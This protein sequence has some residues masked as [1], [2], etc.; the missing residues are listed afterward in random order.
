M[1]SG[2]CRGLRGH[3]RYPAVLSWP[4]AFAR[5][6][7]LWPGLVSVWS[8]DAMALTLQS[9]VCLQSLCCWNGHSAGRIKLVDRLLRALTQQWLF[10][11]HWRASHTRHQG[12]AGMRCALA[13]RAAS[14][15]ARARGRR[16]AAGPSSS[17]AACA[18]TAHCCAAAQRRVHE[19]PWRAQC[20]MRAARR[21]AQDCM[22]TALRGAQDC[23]H[24]AQAGRAQCCTTDSNTFQ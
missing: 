10:P 9:H 19:A 22:H 11:G 23:M 24:T 6:A 3:R 20:C 16:E 4:P 14:L 18:S 12:P 15:H 2:A 13:A 7:C 5:L 8:C 1:G 21:R 17:P